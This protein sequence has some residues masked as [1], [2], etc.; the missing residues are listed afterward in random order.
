MDN[1]IT[2]QATGE[3]ITFLESTPDVLRFEDSLPADHSGV[4]AHLHTRQQE[5]FTVLS[6]T[7]H[8]VIDGQ[9]Y[10]LAAGERLTI[11]AGVPHR[12]H[13][14]GSEAVKLLVELQPALDYEAMFRGLAQAAAQNRIVPLQIAAMRQELDLGFYLGGPPRRLQ[15]VL[16]AAMAVVARRLGYRTQYS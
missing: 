5:T 9:A 1:T 6:G 15:D 7:F 3:T 8:A 4:P 11:P 12:F 13:T 2:N 14:Q 16:F 10:T